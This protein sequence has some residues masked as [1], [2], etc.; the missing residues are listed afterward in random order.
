MAGLSIIYQWTV[1]GF[2]KQLLVYLAALGI[3]YVTGA[4]ISYMDGDDAWWN[5]HLPFPLEWPRYWPLAENY[6]RDSYSGLS[7]IA[8]PSQ[9]G[10]I[11]GTPGTPAKMNWNDAIAAINALNYAGHNDWRMPNTLE[12]ESILD[13]GKCSPTTDGSIFKNTAGSVWFS[14]MLSV[15]KKYPRGAKRRSASKK[16]ELSAAKNFDF[17]FFSKKFCITKK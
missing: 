5:Q 13:Y 2:V 3:P 16:L 11:W 4:T 17:R 6:V 1:K 10:G 8:D 9:L 7:W 12:L 14:F 15:T